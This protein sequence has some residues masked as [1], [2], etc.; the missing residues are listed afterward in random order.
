MG[1]SMFGTM[2]SSVKMKSSVP[3][4]TFGAEVLP[5]RRSFTRSEIRSPEFDLGALLNTIMI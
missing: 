1:Q 2:S 5:C 3:K 4:L